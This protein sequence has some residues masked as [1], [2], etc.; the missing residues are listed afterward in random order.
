M[1][2]WLVGLIT[3]LV[4]TAVSTHELFLRVEL[5]SIAGAAASLFVMALFFVRRVRKG[6]APTDLVHLIEQLNYEPLEI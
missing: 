5:G 3:F 6:V 2:A 1:Y 4:A